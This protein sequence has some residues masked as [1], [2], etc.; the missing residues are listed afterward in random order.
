MVDSKLVLQYS[1][2][3]NELMVLLREHELNKDLDSKSYQ[4]KAQRCRWLQ[5]ELSRLAQLEPIPFD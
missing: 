2:E 5:A 1:A 3:Y 4:A